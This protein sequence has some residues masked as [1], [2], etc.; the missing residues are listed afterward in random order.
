MADHRRI[1]DLVEHHR[2]LVAAQ[3][4][5]DIAGP[6]RI[7]QAF[8]HGSQQLVADVMAKRVVDEL[9]AVEIQKHERD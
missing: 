9:E 4:G 6:H 1:G 3:P 7:A 8:G 2:K 5:D